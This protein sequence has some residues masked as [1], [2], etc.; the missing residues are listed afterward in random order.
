MHRSLL[1]TGLAIV[2]ALGLSACN[3]DNVPP[4]PG[5]GGTR[6]PP[7]GTGGTGG[8]GATGG[9]AGGGGTAGTAGRAGAGGV[10]GG[11]GAGG[12]GGSPFRGECANPIDFAALAQ[13]EPNARQIAAEEALTPLCFAVVLDERLF[14]ECVATALPTLSTAC[15][16]CYGELAWCSGNACNSKCRQDSCS[17]GEDGCFACQGYDACLKKLQDCTGI[18]PPDCPET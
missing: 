14:S 6:P 11:A 10:G 12:V 1:V 4:A 18:T 3:E 5:A 7:P 8:S 13:L 9:T 16:L 17:L 2:L 15:A